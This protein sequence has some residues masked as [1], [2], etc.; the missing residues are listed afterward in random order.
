LIVTCSAGLGSGFALSAS[1][2]P[3]PS[4]AAVSTTATS[5]A[6]VLPPELPDPLDLRLTFMMYLRGMSLIGIATVDQREHEI[7]QR[8]QEK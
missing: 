2:A 5:S 8:D 1:A 4:I 6:F 7:A 3:A